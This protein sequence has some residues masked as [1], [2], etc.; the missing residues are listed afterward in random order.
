MN[1][2][3]CCPLQGN[4]GEGPSCSSR[5]VRKARKEH[6]CSECREPIPKGAKYDYAS[7]VWDGRPDS[8]KTCLLCVEIRD[9]FACE[10]W[11]YETL[12]S[13]LTE[14]FFPDMKCGG[15]CMTGLSPEAKRKLIDARMEWYFEQDEIDDSAWEDWPKNKDV[16]RPVRE[17]PVVEPKDDYY[18]LP[19]VYWPE[20]LKQEELMRQ[21]EEQEKAKP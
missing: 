3:V 7:G 2:I 17:V 8:F 4:D 1:D 10:G 5:A 12:W 11:I 15:Q 18:S 6:V 9:H 16:Q 14:N 19:E 21:Y 13:D 20:R